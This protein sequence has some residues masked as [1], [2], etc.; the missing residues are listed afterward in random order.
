MVE[1][2]SVTIISC[3]QAFAIFNRLQNVV[4]LTPKQKTE[5][6]QEIKKVI[7]SCPIIIQ[8]D[9]QK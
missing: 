5:F 1:I 2:F 6:I 8:N 3:F 9:T 7:P 4:E